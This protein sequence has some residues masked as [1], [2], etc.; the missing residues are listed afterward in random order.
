MYG[1]RY[2]SANVWLDTTSDTKRK[3]KYSLTHSNGTIVYE[4]VITCR[5]QGDIQYTCTIIIVALINQY[6]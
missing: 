2:S 1:T 5:A 3:W 6:N 4:T